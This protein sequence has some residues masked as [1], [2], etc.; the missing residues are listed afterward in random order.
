MTLTSNPNLN[1][2]FAESTHSLQLFH[3]FGELIL[4]KFTWTGYN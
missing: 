1:G 2:I 4:E 3:N